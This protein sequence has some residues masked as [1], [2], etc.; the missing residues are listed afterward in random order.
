M[1]TP[2]RPVLFLA[3]AWLM[4]AEIID[5]IAVSVGNRVITAN[6]IDREIRVTAFQN[7]TKPDFSPAHR[8]VIA[9]RLIEQTLIRVELES[10]RYPLPDPAD[11]KPALDQFKRDNFKSDD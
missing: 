8:N 3:A 10:S 7:Q 5:R 2:I 1:L 4:P 11:I 6:D 9:D